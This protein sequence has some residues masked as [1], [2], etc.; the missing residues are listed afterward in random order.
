MRFK[1]KKLLIAISLLP[2]STSVYANDVDK[3]AELEEQIQSLK[4]TINEL[5]KEGLASSEIVGNKP[6]PGY[7]QVVGT[8]TE[9]KISGFVHLDAGVIESGAGINDT[10]FSIY[11][12]VLNGTVLSTDKKD[13]LDMS[14]RRSRLNFDAK[15]SINDKSLI[16][17]IEL[18]MLGDGGDEGF[19]NGYDARIRQA[20]AVYDGWLI[21]QSFTTFLNFA[22]LG[23]IANFGQHANAL[24]IRQ[25]Q[26]RYTSKFDGGS[27][28][29]ALENPYEKNVVTISGEDTDTNSDDQLIP[30]LIGRVD[31]TGS[32][33][34]ASLATLVR[35]FVM[36]NSNVG[37]SDDSAWGGA[38]SGV[39][40]FPL[41]S[42]SLSLQAN[43]GAL[44]RY[45]E[46][47]PYPDAYVDDGELKPYI[48]MGISAIYNYHWRPDLRSTFALAMTDSQENMLEVL[49][50]SIDKTS[51][52][53]AN[54]FWDPMDKTTLGFEYGLYGI[55][56]ADGTKQ[57]VYR[58]QM[59]AQFNF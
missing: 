27:W 38:I 35:K 28:S 13:T 40:R 25:V 43:Y 50:T 44:G 17:H 48:T 8:D 14:I 49:P 12:P 39:T 36:D 47:G 57:N 10:N 53:Q 30:D 21:G 41:F 15:T 32:W 5:K 11:A 26:I 7:I 58:W 52:I 54:L 16:T 23:E 46:L 31:F 45:L 51:S 20:Y 4:I 22:S 29:L 3:L 55:E 19:T 2:L 59:T 33:G 24:F 34:T 37:G 18:D 1:F 6:T 42:G 9:F 56:L